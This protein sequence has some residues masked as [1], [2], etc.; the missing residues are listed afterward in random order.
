[1]KVKL[2]EPGWERYTGQFGIYWFVDGVSTTDMSKHDAAR[3]AAVMRIETEDGHNPSVAQS[4]VDNINT[5]APHFTSNVMQ[6][7]AP[8]DPEQPK[9]EP[10]K[11]PE[12]PA[13]KVWTEEELA[14][15]ADAKGIKGLREI[16]E[17]MGIKGTSI[18][19]LIREIQAGTQ[20]PKE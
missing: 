14:A 9:V 4:L 2:V 18:K 19:E 20:L 16:A 12:Q 5:P 13:Q 8:K 3:I 15:V 17:P 11:A 10:D 7:E 1:M 6:P